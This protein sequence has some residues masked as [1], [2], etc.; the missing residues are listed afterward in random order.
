MG[1]GASEDEHQC[2]PLLSLQPQFHRPHLVELTS[3]ELRVVWG[4]AQSNGTR[5]CL[6]GAA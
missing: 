6:V 5:V 2:M 4:P 1:S 3:Q